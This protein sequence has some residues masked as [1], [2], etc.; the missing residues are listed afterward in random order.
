MDDTLAPRLLDRDRVDRAYPLV[1]NIAPQITLERWNRFV[2]PLLASRSSVW[3][4]GVMTIQNAAECILG[5]FSFEVRDELNDGRTL[6]LDN[7]VTASIPGRDAIWAAVMDAADHLAQVHG[8]RAIRAGLGGDLD[9]SDRDR[10]WLVSSLEGAGFAL[11]G[12][13]ACKRLDAPSRSL[14]RPAAAVYGR[15]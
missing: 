13:R 15:P 10:A 12:I 1:R 8:C 6:L 9:T 11:D 3:P 2:R 4:R 7:I 5:L 14:P